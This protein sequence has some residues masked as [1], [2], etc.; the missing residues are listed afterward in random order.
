MKK[1]KTTPPKQGES[2]S[3][4]EEH[5]WATEGELIV[6]F[7]SSPANFMDNGAQDGTED[8]WPGV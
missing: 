6:F 2:A 5:P 8:L 1:R 4:A 3:V 7:D